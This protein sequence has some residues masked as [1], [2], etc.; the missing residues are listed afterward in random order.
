MGGGSPHQPARDAQQGIHAHSTFSLPT[1]KATFWT[2]TIV[3][4]NQHF[5]LPKR[6]LP[7]HHMAVPFV[8]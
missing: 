7:A 5:Y 4:T 3:G 6:G 2:A 1:N 8:R